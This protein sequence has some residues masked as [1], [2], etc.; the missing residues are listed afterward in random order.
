MD[1]QELKSKLKRLRG[2]LREALILLP[3]FTQGKEIERLNQLFKSICEIVFSDDFE[4]HIW[5][6][7]VLL[8][9]QKLFVKKRQAWL[10][11]F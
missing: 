9:L 5:D 3:L 8:Q 10:V 7:A 2:I 1:E 6:E 11:G 4:L